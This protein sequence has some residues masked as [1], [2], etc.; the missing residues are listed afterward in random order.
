MKAVLT[1]VIFVSFVFTLS[2]LSRCDFFNIKEIRISGNSAIAENDLREIAK[3]DLLGNYLYLFSKNNI[4]LYPQNLI[5]NNVIE[6][7]PRIKNI[8]VNLK[9]PNI[10]SIDVEERN[11]YVLWCGSASTTSCYFADDEGYIFADSENDI[12]SNGMFRYY[13]NIDTPLRQN[14]FPTEKFK[15]ID[16]FV[17]FI[18]GLNLEPYKFVADKEKYEIYFGENSKIIFYE[19]QKTKEVMDNLQAILNMEEFVNIDDFKKLEYLDLRF[20]N[21]V[22]YK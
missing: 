8:D 15:E 9:L 10:L 22:F 14:I 12:I 16:S 21:K 6:N 1:F 18:K 19:T 5:E 2:Q 13:T 4:I 3:E 7:F 17:K 11:P 20:G